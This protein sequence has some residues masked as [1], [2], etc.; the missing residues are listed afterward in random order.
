MEN[1]VKLVVQKLFDPTPS[2][3]AIRTFW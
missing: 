3:W 1:A 2:F